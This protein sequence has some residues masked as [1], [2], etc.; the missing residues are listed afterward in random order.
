MQTGVW[1]RYLKETVHLE[2]LGIDGRII[3]RLIL[4]KYEG[5]LQIGLIWLRIRT[6]DGHL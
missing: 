2:D 6:G 3:I 5:N 1:W 4:K